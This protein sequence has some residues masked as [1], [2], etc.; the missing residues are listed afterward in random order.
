[1]ITRKLAESEDRNRR[2]N[3]RLIGVPEDQEGNHLS[4]FA[5]R[6]LVKIF[7]E[8][9]LPAPPDI[10][11]A[12]RLPTPRTNNGRPRPIIVRF[13]RWCDKDRILREAR[14]RGDTLAYNG[15]RVRFFEDF[16]AETS[17]LRA[18]FA[19]AKQLI[20]ERGAFPS[21][22]HPAKL[23]VKTKDGKILMF[24]DPGEA[25]NFARSLPP[26]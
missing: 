9:F 22:R 2:N 25:M 6:L 15:A 12:H 20:F 24:S 18:K 1:M 11:V 8:E 26:N 4:T 19:P 16:S 13:T 17:A 10:D 23:R 14:R 3:L 5:P 21:L 7:G